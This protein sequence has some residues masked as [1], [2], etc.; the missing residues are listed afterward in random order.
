MADIMDTLH[1]EHANMTLLLDFL[2][3]QMEVF[4]RADEPDYVLLKNVIDYTLAY[5][6]RYHHPKED[7]VYEK[8]LARDA[9]AADRTGDLKAEHARLAELS[10]RFN[11]VIESVLAESVVS[12]GRVVDVAR[13]FING[14]RKHMEMEETKETKFF[15]AALDTLAEEDWTAIKNAFEH[16]DDPLFGRDVSD[17]FK[18][19]RQEISL[20]A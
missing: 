2:E 5:P 7:L 20:G 15:P 10:H 1:E 11:E 17:S 8:L 13:E 3:G 9:G 6:D 14:T 4:A 19:L 12:R 18:A 16:R